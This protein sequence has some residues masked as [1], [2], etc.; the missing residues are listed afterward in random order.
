M[1][2]K[3]TICVFILACMVLFNAPSRAEETEAPKKIEIKHGMYEK[4]VNQRFGDPLLV[5]EMKDKFWP[6]PKKRSLYEIGESDYMI[7]YFFSGRINKITILSDMDRDQAVEMFNT[8]S[9]GV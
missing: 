5:Q 4:T 6:I 9:P 8:I 3:I 7:L 1:K 2:I